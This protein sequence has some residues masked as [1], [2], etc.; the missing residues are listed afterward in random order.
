MAATIAAT[1]AASRPSEKFG[2]HSISRFIGIVTRAPQCSMIGDFHPRRPL[3][4]SPG[5]PESK[6]HTPR[7]RLF[8]RCVEMCDSPEGAAGKVKA[9]V[10][11]ASNK[12]LGTAGVSLWWGLDEWARRRISLVHL[13]GRKSGLR[14][15][16]RRRGRNLLVRLRRPSRDFRLG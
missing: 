13:F 11:N 7:P 16:W 9:V 5:T 6:R 4:P 2:T 3:V 14:I 15:R 10:Q 1:L 12:H 8:L